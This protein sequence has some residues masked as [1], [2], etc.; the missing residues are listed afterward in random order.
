M[1]S[2][3][4]FVR[5]SRDPVTMSTTSPGRS[6]ES[7]VVIVSA[8]SLYTGAIKIGI[9]HMWQNLRKENTCPPSAAKC[10]STKMALERADSHIKVTCRGGRREGRTSLN[11]S[12]NGCH[13]TSPA[14]VPHT[15]QHKLPSRTVFEWTSPPPFC[16]PQCHDLQEKWNHN[17]YNICR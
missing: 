9:S 12:S 5:W 14:L 6:D 3:S 1:A 4:Y 7:I 15:C 10:Q 8:Q 11:V 13:M 17:H 2:K 16:T